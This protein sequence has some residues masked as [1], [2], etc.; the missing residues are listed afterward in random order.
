MESVRRNVGK[1]PKIRLQKQAG[2]AQT[3][4][5]LFITMQLR[6][7][8]GIHVQGVVITVTFEKIAFYIEDGLWSSK[9]R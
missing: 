8:Q 6:T 7:I 2:R 9:S 3:V 5:Y 4:Q 1:W